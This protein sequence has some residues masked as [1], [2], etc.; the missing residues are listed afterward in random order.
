MCEACVR[1]IQEKAQCSLWLRQVMVAEDQ[2]E[3]I[4]CIRGGSGTVGSVISFLF[5]W[6]SQEPHTSES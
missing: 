4:R 2:W 5:L 3:E 1:F 6:S